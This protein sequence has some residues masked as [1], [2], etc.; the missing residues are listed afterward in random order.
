MANLLLSQIDYKIIETPRGTWRRYMYPSGA[1]YSEF[2]SSTTVLGLPLLH[3][4]SGVSPETGTYAVSRGFLAV[5]RRALGVIAV[6]RLSAGLIAIGQLAVGVISIG[7]AALGLAAL[8]QLALGIALGVGQVTCGVV[9]VGQVAFGKWVLAQLGVGQHVWS[10][11]I[12]DPAA[13]E[14][15]KDL[16]ASLRRVA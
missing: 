4:T 10:M 5:G 3:Y 8:G 1:R 9:C 7:Q 14:F 12:K 16:P 11:R 6:G 15:F 2:T 13:I